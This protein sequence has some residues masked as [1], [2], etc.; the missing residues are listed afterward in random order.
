MFG[1]NPCIIQQKI[2]KILNYL[3]EM[4]TKTIKENKRKINKKL[5]N[6]KK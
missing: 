5:L 6:S 2:R 1:V 3:S 4:G